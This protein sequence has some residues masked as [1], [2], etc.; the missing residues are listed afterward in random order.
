MISCR[1]CG[2]SLEGLDS[3]MFCCPHCG[4]PTAVL[5]AENEVI[6]P[7]AGRN[8]VRFDY[9]V[10]NIG[11]GLLK[12]DLANL[13]AGVTLTDRTECNWRL[14]PGMRTIG[15]EVNPDCLDSASGQ[16]QIVFDVFDAKGNHRY[17]YRSASLGGAVRKH[18]VTL[19][20][21]ERR[22]GPVHVY[23]EM[24]V[25]R[26]C[27]D[28]AVLRLA[29]L[30]EVPVYVA[31]T[32]PDGYRIGLSQE[33]FTKQL[34]V[35]VPPG[36]MEV[37][38]RSESTV[39]A[40]AG[41]GAIL[42]IEVPDITECSRDVSLVWMAD[43]EVR[44]P[45][46]SW[47]IGID[48]GTAKSAVFM[49]DCALP[50]PEPDPVKWATPGR[51]DPRSKVDSVIMYPKSGGRPRFGW[52]VPL[53]PDL[54]DMVIRSIKMRLME[55][56]YYMLPD[57][58]QRTVPEI[59]EEY[60]RFLLEQI[61]KQPQL[62]QHN[63]PFT[64]TLVVFSL[65]VHD[66]D[67][68]YLRQERLTVDAAVAA[69][70]RYEQIAT[71]PEPECA[72]VDFLRSRDKWGLNV[73]DGDLLC[74]FDCGAGTTDISIM[75][76]HINGGEPSFSRKALAGFPVG[77]DVLDQLLT[78][79]FLKQLMTD[80]HATSEGEDRYRIGSTRIL[81]QELVRTLRDQK[82]RLRYPS[83][84]SDDAS[85]VV[86]YGYGQGSF[87]ISWQIIERLF[88]PYLTKMLYHG[89]SP[90]DL[91]QIRQLTNGGA[92]AENPDVRL[93]SLEDVLYESRISAADVRWVCMT[94]GSSLIPFVVEEIRRFF[95]RAQVVPSAEVMAEM[96]AQLDSQLTLNVARGAATRPLCQVEGQ[97]QAQYDVKFDSTSISDE[98]TALRVGTT[99][100]TG[101][102]SRPYLLRLGDEATVRVN[103][104]VGQVTGS[105][106]VCSI[107]NEDADEMMVQIR[108]KYGADQKICLEMDKAVGSKR[109][110]LVRE[111]CI[112]E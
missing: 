74:V 47:I 9:M 38:V 23:N 8:K 55:Q 70:L 52:E 2:Q 60:I 16:P 42:R 56:G 12:M 59:V 44:A 54:E 92:S 13:P 36:P 79:M 58:S 80:G 89:L 46:H 91:A 6:I 100:G 102:S 19:Q 45:E 10:A 87:K 32:A 30:G 21:L 88:E 65:P 34:S 49:T 86:E 67:D 77:G 98:Q 7:M 43:E 31:C 90:I 1:V 51:K 17:D 68:F 15:L 109:E 106:Y 83:P 72:A 75:Q 93:P 96:S 4:W 97:L 50:E 5:Q 105:V 24:L 78:E 20:L 61:K 53:V 101:W 85:H 28:R 64:D 66:N 40:A 57:G 22:Y 108:L 110:P 94:G 18:V 73:A 81:R 35:V 27:T 33:D 11:F 3:D 76:I 14:A 104:S 25:F 63:T 26:R 107:R 62:N 71:Y 99:P 103:A 95:S 84:D 69:G 29:N 82:E 48:F 112:V 111:V 41:V 39:P 37:Y